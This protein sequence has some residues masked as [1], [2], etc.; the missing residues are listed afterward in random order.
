[1]PLTF[2]LLSLM[3]CGVW[4]F[5]AGDTPI[6]SVNIYSCQ[7][8]HNSQAVSGKLFFRL[9]CHKIIIMAIMEMC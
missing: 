8:S 5:P 1:M 9:E 7:F 3:V 4:D 2:T 6:A